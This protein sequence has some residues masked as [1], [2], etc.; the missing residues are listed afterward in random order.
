M[1]RHRPTKQFLIDRVHQLRVIV[2]RGDTGALLGEHHGGVHAREQ[3]A[4]VH[5]VR[6][7]LR[8][9]GRGRLLVQRFAEAGDELREAR[10]VIRLDAGRAHS[11]HDE[12][13]RRLD[14]GADRLRRPEVGGGE[15]GAQH[16]TN[17]AVGL[18]PRGD[19][20][21]DAAVRRLVGDEARAQLGADVMHGGV[22]VGENLEQP[23]SFIL[24]ITLE[25][26][27]QDDLVALVVGPVVVGESGAALRPLDAPAGEDA[28][29]VDDVLL[30][31]AAIDAE[32]VQLEQLA[33]VVFV[34]ARRPGPHSLAPSPH[35]GEGER[36]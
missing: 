11:A 13:E 23:Y 16:G 4:A 33:C 29:D 3:R 2:D 6:L 35:C 15:D 31:V 9:A 19:R 36:A 22:L 28:R 27:A 14:L 7:G 17:V 30:R 34:D 20:G 5:P 1:R 21:I 18:L 8:I 24:T 26:L 12:L 32:R 10:R 25:L